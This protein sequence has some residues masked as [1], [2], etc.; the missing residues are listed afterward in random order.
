MTKLVLNKLKNQKGA[1]ENILVVIFLAIVGVIAL[2][3]LSTWA[4]SEADDMKT[5]AST[6]VDNSL[7]DASGGGN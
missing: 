1:M 4:T 6:Q 7:L 2:L 3:G 5:N